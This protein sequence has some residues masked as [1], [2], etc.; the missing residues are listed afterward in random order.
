MDLE[1]GS[2]IA[3]SHL[4][5]ATG[6]TPNTDVLNLAAA[7]I[8]ADRRGFIPV[9]ERLQTTAPNVYAIGD[10]NGGP[11]FTHISYDD[12]R[13]L[14][15]RLLDG[16][17]TTTTGRMTPYCVFSDPMLGRIGLSE[18]EARQGGRPVRVAKL[19][20]ARVAR[21]MEAS[22]S[23]GFMKAIV[24]AQ[25]ERILGAAVLGFEGGELM[26]LFQVAMMGNLPYTALRDAIWAHP[27]NAEALNNLFGSFS[28]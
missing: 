16:E 13:I 11:A 26:A 15:R 6:R 20:M 28:G 4:L 25:T 19:A 8:E 17:D 23:R 24:D 3:G 2:T 12:F 1:A 14:K 10:V 5:V 27:T 7:G 21:A 22:E 9:N 18:T